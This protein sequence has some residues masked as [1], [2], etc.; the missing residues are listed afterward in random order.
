M[1]LGAIGVVVSL[2]CNVIGAIL[3]GLDPFH[4]LRVYLTFPLGETVL[5]ESP[6]RSDNVVLL[7]A[8]FA[9]YLF[10]GMLLGGL[11]HSFLTRWLVRPTFFRRF[12]GATTLSLAV[13]VLVFYATLSWLQPLLIGGSW[14]V[15]QIPW[16]VG[17]LSNLAF[18]WTVLLLPILWTFAMQGR[19]EK[20]PA[21][22]EAEVGVYV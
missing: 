15:E 21:P 1:A 5:Q 7:G 14:I 12:L 18:G 9:L 17:A 4:L 11:F 10:A 22:E 20:R 8:S 2:L 13:W 19:S 16:Y 3:A 6:F